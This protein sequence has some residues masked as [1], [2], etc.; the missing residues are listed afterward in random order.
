MYKLYS[1]SW[2]SYDTKGGHVMHTW[3]QI[4]VLQ[5]LGVSST[6]LLVH[7]LTLHMLWDSWAI[8]THVQP[9][10]CYNSKSGHTRIWTWVLPCSW[11]CSN[12]WAIWPLFSRS[13]GWYQQIHRNAVQW[14]FRYLAGM[15]DL[16]FGVW[17]ISFWGSSCLSI[18][19]L[20][21]CWGCRL[22]Q[23]DFNLCP[24]S[25]SHVSF[26]CHMTAQTNC[27]VCLCSSTLYWL[28]VRLR[29]VSSLHIL[30]IIMSL[31]FYIVLTYN[32]SQSAEL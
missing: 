17:A 6:W 13:M 5:Q 20:W 28:I 15:L 18:H 22:L 12:H 32:S 11:V 30:Y 23:W 10:F 24:N 16:L 31:F 2:Q 19:W 25:V 4:E 3:V 1:S 29:Q 9:W 8:S 26:L 21:L 27:T 7:D 14:V